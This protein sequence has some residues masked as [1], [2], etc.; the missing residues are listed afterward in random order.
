[1]FASTSSKAF[2]F[3][4]L[5]LVSAPLL[6]AHCGSGPETWTDPNN[7]SPAAKLDVTLPVDA[8]GHVAENPVGQPV[9]VQIA[10]IQTGP[11]TCRQENSF[12]GCGSVGNSTGS[13]CL[14][15][16]GPDTSLDFQLTGVECD[17]DLC[18][19]I[20]IQH[21]DAATGDTVTL[22]PHAGMVTLRATGTSGSL[23]ASGSVQV[24][25]NCTNTPDAP[26]CQ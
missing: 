12:L 18:D 14:V 1:M 24:V 19:V 20:A 26:D 13:S 10:M 21:G 4:P 9:S 23:V 11:G 17:Q 16:A 22:V 8:S 3:L 2:R 7:S 15:C 5:L 6:L 25:A